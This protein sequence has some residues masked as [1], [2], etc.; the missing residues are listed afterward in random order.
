MGSMKYSKS[1][2]LMS[3]VLRTVDIVEV[4]A[5]L[6]L[7]KKQ[8]TKLNPSR[9][10]YTTVGSMIRGSRFSYLIISMSYFWLAYLSG[11]FIYGPIRKIC[12]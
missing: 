10:V 6:M 9:V 11:L 4:S 8:T 5:G 7:F 12:G 1:L 3:L 2:V